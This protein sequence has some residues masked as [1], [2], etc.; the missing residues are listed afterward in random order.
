[1]SAEILVGQDEEYLWGVLGVRGVRLAA[2]TSHI[3]SGSDD[4]TC[5]LAGVNTTLGMAREGVAVSYNT[6]KLV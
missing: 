2:G 1:M 4:A 3:V 5:G 6:K